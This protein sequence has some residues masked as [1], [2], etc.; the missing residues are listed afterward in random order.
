MEE[1]DGRKPIDS[2][3]L[4]TSS[5]V[6]KPSRSTSN[7]PNTARSSVQTA[8][9]I[10][11]HTWPQINDSVT[12]SQQTSASVQVLKSFAKT[13]TEHVYLRLS[14]ARGADKNSRC[15]LGRVKLLS[16]K[17]RFSC[18]LQ[19]NVTWRLPEWGALWSR[20]KALE[21]FA[22]APREFVCLTMADG[23][24]GKSQICVLFCY[25]A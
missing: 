1:G 17:V 14:V 25:F 8:W 23:A 22:A 15:L 4:N 12:M 2:S 5:T 16:K 11:H 7:T 19:H 10:T 24:D 3:T 18:L 9:Y 6:I 13:T 20:D 21:K